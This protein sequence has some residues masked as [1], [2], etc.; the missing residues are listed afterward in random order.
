FL[1]T[2]EGRAELGRINGQALA[3][4]GTNERGAPRYVWL[5][6]SGTSNLPGMIARTYLDFPFEGIEVVE[7]VA[8]VR[9]F[10]QRFRE[11]W[12]DKDRP[13][14]GDKE[15]AVDGKP[16]FDKK[17]EGSEEESGFKDKDF[18]KDF[19]KNKDG[20]KGK[21]PAAEFR[22]RGP[23]LALLPNKAIVIG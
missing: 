18:P 20:F 11:R 16:D 19:F 22:F 13:F 2:P 10:R 7:T 21:E 5:I 17:F 8:G 1:L 15:K 4:T 6:D 9:L 3:L 23:C 12:K 14:F